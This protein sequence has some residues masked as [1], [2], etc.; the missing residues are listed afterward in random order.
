MSESARCSRLLRASDAQ[1]GSAD[2]S[3]SRVRAG[4]A[5]GGKAIGGRRP[6][7]PPGA[8]SARL[9]GSQIVRGARSALPPREALILMAVINHPWLLD[10]HAEEI[11]QPEFRHASG[12]Q[13]RAA[14]LDAASTEHPMTLAAMRAAISAR[15]QGVLPAPVEQSITHPSDWPAREGA[16]EEDVS[17]WW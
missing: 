3:A 14:I 5:R 15:G 10:T 9:A 16:A 17:L 12:D 13:L 1:I 7:E 8:T 11:A 4:R 2:A 6:P